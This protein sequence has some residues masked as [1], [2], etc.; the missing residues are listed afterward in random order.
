MSP[1][2]L[3]ASAQNTMEGYPVWARSAQDVLAKLGVEPGRGLSAED[4]KR[5]LATDGPNEL[6]KRPPEPLWK[7]ILE[8][9]SVAWDSPDALADL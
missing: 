8:A 7:K 1:D 3:Q 4:A 5:K 6:A 2:R 9:R